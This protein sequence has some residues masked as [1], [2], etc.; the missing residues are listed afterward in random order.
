[1]HGKGR[2]NV[3]EDQMASIVK[4]HLEKTLD[5][6]HT[7]IQFLSPRPFQLMHSEKPERIVHW[8]CEANNDLVNMSIKLAPK[9]YFGIAALPQCHGVSPANCIEEIDRISAMPNMVGV[10]VNPDPS[11]ATDFNVPGMGEEH[12]YPLY[13]KLVKEK[14]SILI[15]SAGC[16]ASADH[17][18]NYF[19]TTETLCILDMVRHKVFDKFPDLKVIVSHG[20]GSVP[21]QVGRWRSSF[22]SEKI[23]FDTELRKFY[24]DSVLYDPDT[25]ALLFKITGPDRCMFGTE[26]PGTGS[27]MNPKTGRLYDDIKPDIDGLASLTADDRALIYEKVVYDAFPRFK[28][29]V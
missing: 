22:S 18:T 4:N 24:Y 13:E 15:H 7:D 21:Y 27:R 11:E 2:L 10:L 6:V 1:M 26:N 19:I 23:D 9:R 25:L 17:Y 28:M 8:W 14:L 16:K 29:P 12:W 3:S 5:E 20:G